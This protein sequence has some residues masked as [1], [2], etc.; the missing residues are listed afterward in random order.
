MG[1]ENSK[2]IAQ[3]LTENALKYLDEFNDNDFVRDLTKSML[4]RRN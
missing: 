1:L 4:T 2:K 3:E